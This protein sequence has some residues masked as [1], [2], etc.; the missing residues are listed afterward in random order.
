MD[1]AARWGRG[2]PRGL[3]MELA[4]ALAADEGGRF[5]EAAAAYEQW[6]RLNPA[7][8]QITLNL[9]VLYWQATDVDTTSGDRLPRDF[10]PH[11]SRRVRELLEAAERQFPSRAEVRFWTK[12]IAWADRG[13]PLDL[14]ECRQLLRAQP[15]YLE[16][17]LALFSSSAGEEAEP[18]AMRLLAVHSEQPTAR[19]RYVTSVINGVL[20]RRRWRMRS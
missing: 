10:R 8:L 15:G 19:G 4:D 6:L 20:Q 17:A 16:P 13:E 11:A 3:G 7:D 12:Y 2:P 18:E 5:Q 9:L 1:A 14:L